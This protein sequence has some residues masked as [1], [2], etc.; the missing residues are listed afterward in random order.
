MTAEDKP[1]YV[2]TQKMSGTDLHVYETVATLEYLGRPVTKK[3]LA[4]AVALDDQILDDSLEALIRTGALVESE[5]ADQPAFVPARRD[6]S[7]TPDRP[8]PAR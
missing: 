7:T 2:D 1:P 8:S 4:A 6:W 5:F 3:E